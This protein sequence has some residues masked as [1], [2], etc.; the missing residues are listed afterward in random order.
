MKNTNNAFTVLLRL[1]RSGL[2]A[3]LAGLALAVSVTAARAQD[4]TLSVAGSSINVNLSTGLS[5]WTLGGVD[6]LGQQSFYYSLGGPSYSISTISSPSTPQFS[7][8][9]FG[10]VVLVTNMAVTYQNS[11]L[12]V[13]TA[14]TLTAEGTSSELSTT[15][16]VQNVSSGTETLQLYQL[17]NFTLGG[18]P[19]GQA[20]QFLQT[21]GQY[22]VTQTG[23]GT[24]L[25]GYLTSLSLGTVVPGVGEIAGTNDFGLGVGM[26]PNFNDTS[27]S[28]TGSVDYAYEFDV[29][30]AAGASIGI[31]E[32]QVVPE[33]S[34]VALAAFGL[35]GLVLLRR[36]GLVFLKK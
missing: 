12:S 17:S 2:V 33:P 24:V 20:V 32:I 4:Y 27:L 1:F 5:D 35:L 31:S 8:N 34:S 7:G 36:F 14:Y 10:T 3:G 11:S 25:N 19:G 16:N 18:V 22:L 15:L 13:K 28:A 29:T 21:N 26:A 9:G 23:P 6:E 30:L